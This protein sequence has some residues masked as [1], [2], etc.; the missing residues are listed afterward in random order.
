MMRAALA[1][2][3]ALG[4]IGSSLMAIQALSDSGAARIGPVTVLK[5]ARGQNLL[6]ERALSE[7]APDWA[8]AEAASREALS[9][10]PYSTAA[11]LRLAYID[12]LRDGA[13]SE[14]GAK[15]VETSYDLLAYD[16]YVAQWRVGFCLLN[17]EALSPAVQ[18]AVEA[19]AL[20]F[21]RT[22]RADRM[23]AVLRA[24]STPAAKAAAESWIKKMSSS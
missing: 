13:L 8:A 24:A 20:A 19:E 14:A 17:W 22:N 16:Q 10:Y 11:W 6:A 18:R 4:V 15:W 21:G 9:I 5:T 12:F 7:P 1:A 2:V 3:L 23:L